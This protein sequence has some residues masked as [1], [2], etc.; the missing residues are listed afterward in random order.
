MFVLL[1]KKRNTV[2]TYSFDTKKPLSKKQ[3]QTS[4]LCFLSSAQ[5]Q[6]P[7]EELS[8]RQLPDRPGGRTEPPT[9]AAGKPDNADV[10]C[11]GML[12]STRS[13]TSALMDQDIQRFC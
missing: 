7:W 5:P 12:Y 9:S 6:S 4:A 10:Q 11:G 13:I 2:T 3:N 1:G 8:R